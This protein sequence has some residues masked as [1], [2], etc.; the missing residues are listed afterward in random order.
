MFS[1]KYALKSVASK[2]SSTAWRSFSKTT[3]ILADQYDVVVVGKSLIKATLHSK[4]YWDDLAVSHE[5]FFFCV[6]FFD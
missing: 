1:T 2:T 6:T 5:G 3:S 4:N